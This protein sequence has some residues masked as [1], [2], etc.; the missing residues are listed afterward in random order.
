MQR[1]ATDHEPWLYR[2]EQGRDAYLPTGSGEAAGS[3]QGRSGCNESL[4]GLLKA[5]SLVA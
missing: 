2:K 4:R 1:S 3:E 5:D